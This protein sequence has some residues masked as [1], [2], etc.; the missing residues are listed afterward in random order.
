LDDEV[1]HIIDARLKPWRLAR[2]VVS[3]FNG[4][5]PKFMGTNP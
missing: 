4:T 2:F 1:I 5:Q 3:K